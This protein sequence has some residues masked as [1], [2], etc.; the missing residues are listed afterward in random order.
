MTRTQ[1]RRR[2]QL[3][4]DGLLD[5]ELERERKRNK[6]ELSAMQH[7]NATLL[8][9]RDEA[10]R[11]VLHLRALI[12]GQAH[13]M[14]HIVKSLSAAPE[15]SEYLEEGFEDLVSEDDHTESVELSVSNLGLNF[16]SRTSR[17]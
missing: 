17:D 3:W 13:H 15:L 8:R 1:R 9:Q 11:V 14:E 7:T 12:D 5:E 4:G 2:T 10:Q 16:V 6:K